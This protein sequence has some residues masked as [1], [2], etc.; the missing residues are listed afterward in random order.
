MNTSKANIATATSKGVFITQ[1]I[2]DIHGINWSEKILLS[3]IFHFN[4]VAGKRVC[5]ASDNY[6]SERLGYTKR[7]IRKMLTKLESLGLIYRTN[8]TDKRIIYVDNMFWD[9]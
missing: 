5:Y 1:K 9:E 3:I 4:E 6:F 8:E 7:N 2:C